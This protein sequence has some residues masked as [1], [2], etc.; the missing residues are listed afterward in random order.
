MTPLTASRLVMWTEKVFGVTIALKNKLYRQVNKYEREKHFTTTSFTASA[1]YLSTSFL[2]LRETLTK[3]L[4]ICIKVCAY[5]A[6]LSKFML[7]HVA[8]FDS[9]VTN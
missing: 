9:D 6:K 4:A 2:F 1:L 3:K 5:V 7:Y 8:K